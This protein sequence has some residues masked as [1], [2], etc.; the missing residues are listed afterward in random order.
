M[1]CAYD[2]FIKVL[3]V[4]MVLLYYL[5]LSRGVRSMSPYQKLIGILV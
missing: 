4:N 3:V 5:L 1:S 2:N